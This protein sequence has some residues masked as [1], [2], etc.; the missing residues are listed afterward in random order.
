[1]PRVGPTD[2][3]CAYLAW[4][5]EDLQIG[6][7]HALRPGG[8]PPVRPLLPETASTRLPGLFTTAYDARGACWNSS[9][10]DAMLDCDVAR[11]AFGNCGK[12]TQVRI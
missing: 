1:M 11:I 9:H 12:T 7:R 3:A 2:V 4:H 6:R 10:F 5:S 8:G